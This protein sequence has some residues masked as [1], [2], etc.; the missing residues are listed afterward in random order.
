M[1]NIM[2][3]NSQAISNKCNEIASLKSQVTYLKG[4]RCYNSV[5]SQRIKINPDKSE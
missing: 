2:F 3:T 5:C 4:L 1:D